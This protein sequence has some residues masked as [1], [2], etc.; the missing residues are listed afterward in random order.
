M[1]N[2]KALKNKFFEEGLTYDDVLL[3][4]AYSEVLPREVDF[5]TKI[6]RD[7]KLN[8]PIVSAA[9]DTVTEANM[10]IAMA[11]HGGIGVVHKNMPIERQAEEIDR[12]KWIPHWGRERIYGMIENRPDWCGSWR[13]RPC[14]WYRIH[15][16]KRRYHQHGRGRHEPRF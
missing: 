10:A 6:T 9:M 14:G 12:V 5:S 7:L 11:Q 3:V 16:R 4:P 1:E 13:P 8:A 2:Q 15:L